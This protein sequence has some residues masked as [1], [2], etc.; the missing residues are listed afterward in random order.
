MPKIPLDDGTNILFYAQAKIPTGKIH[1]IA[2]R[3]T[4]TAST[5]G[6]EITKKTARIDVYFPS[7][8][9]M[10]LEPKKAVEDEDIRNFA[11]DALHKL[12]E[13]IGIIDTGNNKLDIIY[14]EDVYHSCF[15]EM[16]QWLATKP[17]LMK[18][19]AD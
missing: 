7:L 18:I 15:A 16:M 2:W 8:E 1:M 13:F 9:P 4:N 17:E 3:H 10:A 6:I 19:V 12:G 5:G 11:R 14:E